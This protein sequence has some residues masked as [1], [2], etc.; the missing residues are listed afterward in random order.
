MA[1]AGC[2]SRLPLPRGEGSRVR[3]EARS[4]RA[5]L[6]RRPIGLIQPSRSPHPSSARSRRSRLRYP[7]REGEG[8]RCPVSMPR[9][10]VLFFLEQL[11]IGR[12]GRQ[13]HLVALDGCDEDPRHI[14]VMPLMAATRRLGLGQLDPPTRSTIPTC[15]PSAPM[16]SICSRIP[17]RFDMTLLL[18]CWSSGNAWGPGWML[19]SRSDLS[20]RC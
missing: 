17:E 5:C 15:T 2:G 18:G 7:P 16:T 11:G 14:V 20:P 19:S 10:A 8:D 6:S 4:I 3:G 9:L 12:I 1:G 13:P